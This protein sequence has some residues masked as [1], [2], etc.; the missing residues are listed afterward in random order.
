MN[1]RSLE[2]ILVVDDEEETLKSVELLLLSIGVRRIELL[3][4]SRRV[5]GFL[6]STDVS[7][8]LLDLSMPYISG[9]DL[10]VHG[11]SYL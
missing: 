6:E 3:S 10:L 1:L 11:A 2:P 9:Q 8:I 4:D 7:V 5:M